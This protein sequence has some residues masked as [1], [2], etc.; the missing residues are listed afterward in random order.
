LRRDHRTVV[1][2]LAVTVKDSSRSLG[3]R[4]FADRAASKAIVRDDA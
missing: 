2:A 4:E 1:E 3:D